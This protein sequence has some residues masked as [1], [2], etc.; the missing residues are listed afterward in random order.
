MFHV[1]E[2]AG[3]SGTSSALGTQKQE[4]AGACWPPSQGK[5]SSARFNARLYLKVSK[6]EDKDDQH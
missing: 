6:V 3:H 4:D 2:K 5:L 1:H